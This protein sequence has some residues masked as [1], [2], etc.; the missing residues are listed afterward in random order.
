M[1]LAMAF[2]CLAALLVVLRLKA[3]MFTDLR[4]NRI[5][6]PSSTIIPDTNQFSCKS[7]MNGTTEQIPLIA[8]EMNT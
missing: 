4:L 6:Y 3:S 8:K 5:L 2:E 7:E 1:C